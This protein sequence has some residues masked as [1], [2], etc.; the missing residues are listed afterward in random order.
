MATLS[1]TGMANQMAFGQHGSAF[2][3]G[4]SGAYSPPT[5]KVVVAI[6]FLADATLNA[7]T[8]E[9]TSDCFGVATSSGQGTNHNLVANNNIFPKG[10]TVYGR[11]TQVRLQTADEDGGA[12]LYLGPAK[13]PIQTA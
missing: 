10:I 11:W 4:D 3:D 8:P 12:I 1:N 6:Q 2:I 7:L 9:T 13:S 5:G